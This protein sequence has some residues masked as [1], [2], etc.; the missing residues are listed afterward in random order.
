MSE[1]TIQ[2]Q[3]TSPVTD[4][5]PVAPLEPAASPWA[6]YLEPLPESVRPLV[7]PVFKT[8][9]ADVTKKFQS[10]HSEFDPY[11]SLIDEYEPD[12]LMQA[13]G[14]I[15][16]MQEN[17]QEFFKQMTEAYGLQTEQGTAN[18]PVVPAT[19]PDDSDPYDERFG[20]L[21][22]MLEALAQVIVG[23]REKVQQ[24]ENEQALE[25][26]VS[27]LKTKH[28]EF[29]E[30]YVLTLMSQGMDPD[31]A[32]TQFKNTLTDYATKLNAPNSQA[33]T[34]VSSNGGGYPTEPIQPKDL[35]DKDTKNLVVQMLAAA[36]AAKG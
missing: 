27:D 4:T 30:L 14:L 35:S 21:E 1:P 17:P 16:F 25:T 23:E 32:V 28:G 33:P 24:T 34:V 5:P 22:G 19:D 7:E 9:D 8:W 10:L 12:A 15:N 31:A 3:G 29:D 18:A 2:G 13:V 36:A 26:L 11:K 6:D 20:K